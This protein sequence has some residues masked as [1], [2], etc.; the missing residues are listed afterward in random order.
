MP[1]LFAGFFVLQL[2]KSNIGNAMTDNFAADIG[3]GF[4]QVNTGNSLLQAGIVIFEIPFNIILQLLGAP[5]WIT[6]QIMA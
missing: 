5:L 3:I 6:F 4:N 1:L 2:D